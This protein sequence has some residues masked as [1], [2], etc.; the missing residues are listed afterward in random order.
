MS[1]N[2]CRGYVKDVSPSLTILTTS[3][4]LDHYP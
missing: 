1:L 4:T 2:P 3:V